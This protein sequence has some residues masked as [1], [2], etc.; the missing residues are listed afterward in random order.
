MIFA[1][2][3]TS[4]MGY[5]VVV[6]S[7]VEALHHGKARK[8]MPFLIEMNVFVAGCIFLDVSVSRKHPLMLQ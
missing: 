3:H 8:W 2:L 5:Q 7:G 1:V 6:V 4:Q